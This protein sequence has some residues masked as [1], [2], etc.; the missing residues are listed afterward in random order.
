[1]LA[2]HHLEV[3]VAL[4]PEVLLQEERLAKLLQEVAE[5]PQLEMLH[6]EVLEGTKD[7]F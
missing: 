4:R 5:I 2:K 7:S 1:M 6:Q 3:E